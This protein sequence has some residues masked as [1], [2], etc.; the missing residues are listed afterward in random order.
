VI[1]YVPNELTEAERTAWL[2]GFRRGLRFRA[3][4]AASVGD[5]EA[6]LT[7]LKV[8][9]AQPALDRERIYGE[10]VVLASEAQPLQGAVMRLRQK[11]KT[12][13]KTWGKWEQVFPSET[14]F[15]RFP[16]QR[17]ASA[18]WKNNR[19]AVQIYPAGDGMLQVSVR[20]HLQTSPISWNE[21]QRIKDE[22]IGVDRWAVE[23]YPA[24]DQIVNA[25]DMRHL[26][27]LP[28]GEQPAFGLHHP[29]SWGRTATNSDYLSYDPEAKRKEKEKL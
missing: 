19:Y 14:D 3:F 29:A 5:I 11:L 21:L 24:K 9:I 13:A 23:I 25:A 17:R 12:L 1:A 7:N 28:E 6:V 2:R 18:F 27:V 22:L 15:V 16:T 8:A 26:W 20:R 10:L 4:L